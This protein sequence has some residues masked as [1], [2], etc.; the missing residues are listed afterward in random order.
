VRFAA[1]ALLLAVACSTASSGGPDGPS[2]TTGAAG[3]AGTGEVM[4]DG[5]ACVSLI[6]QHADEGAFHVP[7]S[8]APTYDTKPPSSGNHYAIWADYKTYTTPVPWGH[9]MHSMEHGAVVIVYNCPNGCTDE[10]AAA[11][12]MI[13]ALPIDADCTAPTKRRVILAP[14]PTLD[15]RWAATAWTWTLRAPCFDAPTFSQFATEH[16]AKTAENFCAE[17][18]QPLCTP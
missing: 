11:Q 4:S 10:V 18:H 7:C 9:L 5:G 1:L 6:Q 14:D 2:Q 12:A 15:V 17:L 3:D 13:D 16:Y 8:P